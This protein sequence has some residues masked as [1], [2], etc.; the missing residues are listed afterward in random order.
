MRKSSKGAFI[1]SPDC[2]TC[3]GTAK[4]FAGMEGFVNQRMEQDCRDTFEPCPN[5]EWE[6]PDPD[7]E[8]E[9][10]RERRRMAI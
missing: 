2:E 6:E 7:H 10:M 9:E 3:E 8:M 5:A 4:V 1:C